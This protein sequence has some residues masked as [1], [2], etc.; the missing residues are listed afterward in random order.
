MQCSFLRQDTMRL[1]R[2]RIGEQEVFLR[3]CLKIWKIRSFCC[4]ILLKIR[5]IVRFRNIQFLWERTAW[6]LSAAYLKDLADGLEKL[7]KVLVLHSN[8]GHWILR[9]SLDLKKIKF[10]KLLRI[11]WRKNLPYLKMRNQRQA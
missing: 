1:V 9:I 2:K 8:K 7:L 3:A 4:K 10:R 6:L 11:S 5:R